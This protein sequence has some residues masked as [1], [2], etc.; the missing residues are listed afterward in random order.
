MADRSTLLR[1]LASVGARRRDGAR[2]VGHK[3]WVLGRM[4]EAGLPVPE[5]WVLDAGA[6]AQFVGATLRRDHEPRILVKLAGSRVGDDRCAR[7]YEALGAA[8]LPAGLLE[9][10]RGPFAERLASLPGGVAVRASV[11]GT[12]AQAALAAR[13]LRT[14][15]GVT[16]PDAVL[17]AIRDL[18]V[19]SVLS[20]SIRACAQAEL[21]EPTIAI[22]LQRTVASDRVGLITRADPGGRAP[23]GWQLGVAVDAA[24]PGGRPALLLAPLVPAETPRSEPEALARLRAALGRDGRS[25]LLAIGAVAERELGAAAVVHFAVTDRIELLA[26]DEG[27]RWETLRGGDASTTWAELGF[28]GA[29][30][31]PRTV[32]SNS[33]AERAARSAV[34]ATLAA[35]R[36]GGDTA[37]GM[38]GAAAERLYLNLDLAAGTARQLPRLA[39]EELLH[40]VGGAPADRL[41]AVAG[42]A[43]AAS[44]SRWRAPLALAAALGEQLGIEKELDRHEEEESLRLRRQMEI[45][46]TLFPD[47]ALATTLAGAVRALE[48]SAA[49]WLRCAGAQL[50]RHAAI[51][52]LVRRRLPDVPATL[53]YRL[54]A[55]G[56]ASLGAALAGEIER[57]TAAAMRDAPGLER[58]RDRATRRLADLPDG[59]LRGALGYCLTRYGDLA[60]DAFELEVPRWREDARPLFDLV[61]LVLDAGPA[62]PLSGRLHRARALAD[63]ELAHVEAAVPILERHALRALVSRCRQLATQRAR[64]EALLYRALG[65]LRAAAVDVDRRLGRAEQGLGAGAVF[66]CS[67][68]R[69]A[70]ALKSGRPELG[71]LVRMHRVEREIVLAEPPPPRCFVGAPPRTGAPLDSRRELRGLGVGAGVAE[72]SARRAAVGAGPPMTLERGDVLVLAAL[73]VALA[74]LGLIAGA[75]VTEAGGALVPGAELCRDLALP[76]V[77]SVPDALGQLRD[78]ERVRVD[79]ERGILLRLD[80]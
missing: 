80:C 32:L 74:P 52:R 59:A 23:N 6:Y 22:L 70:S 12:A 34:T 11:V 79:A 45:D 38:V 69:L 58:L 21:R 51:T 42:R 15:L 77:A 17:A 13:H 48:R 40:A 19:G 67:F 63:A 20:C 5:A 29:G 7:A 41:G 4:L 47:D 54:T 61:A 66:Q 75:F 55:G 53:A 65:G 8:P 68:G 49:L 14:A 71:R 36:T 33:I 72:G 44:R 62:E 56:G 28:G 1:E 9:E 27:P 64:L 25:E 16:T 60:I 10:V 3:A 30:C 78:G 26:V 35:L 18:W 50:V 46:L 39:P 43:A 2:R 37:D 76:L 24:V 31:P 57:V 73:D